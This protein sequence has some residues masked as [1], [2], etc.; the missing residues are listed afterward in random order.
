MKLEDLVDVER[1]RLRL[2]LEGQS[3]FHQW[4]A[5]ALEICHEKYR[6]IANLKVIYMEIPA[7]YLQTEQIITFVRSLL[8]IM[9][10]L[11]EK[12]TLLRAEALQERR[13]DQPHDPKNG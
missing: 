13:F 4:T 11:E 3:V 7:D 12:K 2:G 5:T 10:S 9:P 8:D 1:L 6:E